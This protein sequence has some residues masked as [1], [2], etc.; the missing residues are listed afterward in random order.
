MRVKKLDLRK[1][2]LLFPPSLEEKIGPDN[3]VRLIDSF[4]DSFDIEDLVR[5][6]Q[7]T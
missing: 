3:I 4:V 1:E 5:I 2:K 7:C 6:S